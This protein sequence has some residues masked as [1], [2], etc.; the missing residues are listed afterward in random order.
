MQRVRFCLS[1]LITLIL[2]CVISTADAEIVTVQTQSNL[3]SFSIDGVAISAAEI[4][5][6][7]ADIILLLESYSIFYI[8]SCSYILSNE[9][10]KMSESEY[11]I[12]RHSTPPPS[13]SLTHPPELHA[14]R[15]R[16]P[17]QKEFVQLA[18]KTLVKPQ[19]LASTG[20]GG[21]RDGSGD[22]GSGNLFSNNGG[23]STGAKPEARES[24]KKGGEICVDSEGVVELTLSCGPLKVTFSTEGAT[25][26]GLKGEK[27]DFSL[28]L[29]PT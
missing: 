9:S 11:F 21:S 12:D 28:N 3:C 5:G 24:C 20:G 26:I 22:G 14:V 18:G 1:C 19:S 13:S 10:R 6:D 4:T 7:R 23:R 27:G 2:L 15:I 8:H 25:S 17:S 16:I 29:P